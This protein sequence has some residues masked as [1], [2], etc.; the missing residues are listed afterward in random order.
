MTR[1]R[2]VVND[3][4]RFRD[5]ANLTWERYIALQARERERYLALTG[6]PVR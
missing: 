5:P 3:P 2:I 4:R 6:G 1:M